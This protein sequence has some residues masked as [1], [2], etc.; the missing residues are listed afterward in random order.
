M[1]A[2]GVFVF[3]ASQTV[4][5]NRITFRGSYF[6]WSIFCKPRSIDIFKSFTVFERL[7]YYGNMNNYNVNN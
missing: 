4:V 3:D 6:S 7:D 5:E 1:D 2:V